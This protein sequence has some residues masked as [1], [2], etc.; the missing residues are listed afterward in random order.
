MSEPVFVGVDVSKA[1]LDVATHPR[2]ERRGF[3]NTAAGFEAL[4][5]HLRP[6]QPV[7]V[8]LEATGGYQVPVA[9]A[10]AAA[11]LPVVVVNPRQVRDYARATGRLAKTDAIDAEVL[12]DFAAAIRPEIR[13]LPDQTLRE[14]NAQLSRRRQLSEMLTAER[15]RWAQASASVRPSLEAHIAWLEQAVRECDRDLDQRIRSSP[16]WRAKDDLLQSV[17][18]IGP[19]IAHLLLADLPE[20]GQLTRQK[21]AMLVGVAPLHR[22][23]GQS[24]GRRRCWGGRAPVRSALY[25]AA[26]VASRHNPVIRDFY[27]RLRQAGKEPKVALIACARKLLVILN[28][29]LKNQ[30]P[31]NAVGA[32]TS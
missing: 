20:L 8:V 3:A 9:T 19:R 13:P 4:I 31:W 7:R 17:P 2:G 30:Q 32:A 18:G 28:A 6:L 16:V 1:G 14:L 12:A 22:D 5:A 29:M 27:Q 25:M 24:R 11:G 10:L 15:N 23:S 21:I 26:L